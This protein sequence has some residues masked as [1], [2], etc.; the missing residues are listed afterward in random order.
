MFD[1]I[2]LKFSIKI[3]NK[4]GSVRKKSNTIQKKIDWESL[5][6]DSGVSYPPSSGFT[7]GMSIKEKIKIFSGEF[8]KRQ[9]YSKASVIPGKLKM[10]SLFQKGNTQQNNC[11]INNNEGNEE[12]HSNIIEDDTNE[13]NNDNENK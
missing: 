9:I 8:I 11:N 13:C 5:S 7:P 2:E 1:N 12:F 6:R 10:P 3:I 4:D